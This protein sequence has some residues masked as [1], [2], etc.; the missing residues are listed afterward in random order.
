MDHLNGKS[1]WTD[2]LTRSFQILGLQ[3]QVLEALVSYKKCVRVRT[4]LAWQPPAPSSLGC[5]ESTARLMVAR[6]RAAFCYIYLIK[7]GKK[8]GE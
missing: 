2:Q 3:S 1:K 8:F 6:G 4:T 5:G 7:I